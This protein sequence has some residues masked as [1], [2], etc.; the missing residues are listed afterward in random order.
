MKKKNQKSRLEK[1]I[2]SNLESSLINGGL[3]NIDPSYL[4]TFFKLKD[5]IKL[6][7]VLDDGN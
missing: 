1:E 5:E 6:D 2:I 7:V 3:Q 4:I